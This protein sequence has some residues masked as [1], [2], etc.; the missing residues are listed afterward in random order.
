[1]TS[2]EASGRTVEEAVD[3]ALR[4]V[5]ASRDAVD[6]EI[7]QE[8]RPALLGFGGREARVRVTLRPTAAQEAVAFA[9]GILELMGRAANIRLEEK[10][11]G[12]TLSIHG[13]DAAGLIGRRGRTLDAI[14]LLVALHIQR[15]QGQREQVT[16]DAADYRAKREKALIADA[17]RAADRAVRKGVPVA[18]DPMGPRDR[19]TVHLALREDT[20]VR[21][22]SEGED[23]H[24]HVVVTPR[25]PSGLPAHELPASDDDDQAQP[26][27]ESRP[28]ISEGRQPGDRR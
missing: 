18:M 16:V 2:A 19:R 4:E 26:D 7:L 9:A 13:G 27:L 22:V 10:A 17:H 8:P 24:R 1:M 12:I 3:L 5:G 28:D 21:T 15:R 6:V 14:E 23:E 20:R 25:E 11:E